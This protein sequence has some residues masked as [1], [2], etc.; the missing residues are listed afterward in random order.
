MNVTTVLGPVAAEDLG[1]TLPHEHLCLNLNRGDGFQFR[2][3]PLRETD[4]ELICTE[5]LSFQREG[6]KTV[7]DVTPPDLGRN[8]R[9]LAQIS[10][11]TGLNII[12]GT[13]RYREPFY[14]RALWERTTRSLTAE[15]IQEITE[16][17]DGIFPGIIGEI[18]V[19]AYH[20]SP[21]EERVHR[22]AARAQVETGLPLTTHAL[23]SAVGIDQLDVFEEE[24]VDLT[25]VA[26]GHCDSYPRL[27]FHESI[28]ARGAFVEFD[29]IRGQNEYDTLMQVELICKLVER[30]H[31]HKLLLSQ[32]VCI[33]EHLQAYGGQGYGYVLRSFVPRLLKAGLTESEVNVIL[34]ENPRSFLTGETF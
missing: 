29:L 12:M 5:L 34:I 23:E 24:K 1:I 9:V 16:G 15:F 3:K 21:V 13:G 17:V 2:L 7:I 33:R 25:R 6:G 22:A 8:P 30:G 20:M 31:L 19:H 26:V 14:E 4:R 32:D 28:L 18:G 10:R 27:D 11:E